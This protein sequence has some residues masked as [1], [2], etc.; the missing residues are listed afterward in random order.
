[1]KYFTIVGIITH[2][3]VILYLIFSFVIGDIN[4]INW[5]PNYRLNYILSLILS[6]II[7]LAF[8]FSCETWDNL[9]K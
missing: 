2:I 6:L 9:G 3:A 1:M 5:E 8:L 7:S 4:F